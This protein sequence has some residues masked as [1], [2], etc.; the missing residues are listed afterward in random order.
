M[1]LATRYAGDVQVRSSF[2][3]NS[4]PQ[5]THFVSSGVAVTLDS[6]V[7]LP[8]FGRAVRLVASMG[9]SLDIDVFEGEGAEKRERK[10]AY[11]AALLDM[12]V[13]GM[14]P[15]DWRYDVFAALESCENFV[16][17]KTKSKGRVA[18][19]LP[20]PMEYVRIRRD[21]RTGRKLFDVPGGD[22]RTLT[23]TTDDVFHVRGNTP[24]GGV[25]GVSRILQHRDAVGAQLA[26]QR[27]EG[28]F[29]RNS[30][31]PDFVMEF[32]Q[33]I[34]VEQGREWKA[35]WDSVHAGP[36]SAGQSRAIGGGAKITPIPVSMEDAQFLESKRYG[37]E[38]VGRIMDVHPLLLEDVSK[39]GAGLLAEALAFFVSVQFIPRIRRVEQAFRADPDLFVPT[40]SLYPL[41]KVG[42]LSFASAAT[43][44][45]V[46]HQKI[47]DGTLL[48]DEVR[49]D[50][51]LPPL[52]DGP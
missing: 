42:D 23:L 34:S 19:L 10:D 48:P 25:A 14:S 32:P 50:D 43:R 6:S 33:G 46:Q 45:M 13:D 29:F 51:G 31:R 3:D 35:E 30:A 17:V 20:V 9:A 36:D 52:P 4:V 21:A 27:F 24:Y 22:G 38:D 2:P 5:R 18:E 49:A 12:P 1:I 8:A 41:F 44:S 39:I 40:G 37:V 26:A 7:G 47:Q 11:P 28:A 15:F 16:A